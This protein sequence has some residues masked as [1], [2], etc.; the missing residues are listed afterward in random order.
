MPEFFSGMGGYGNAHDYNEKKKTKGK[1]K[2]LRL[3][4][5]KWKMGKI[6]QDWFNL[7]RLNQSL[8]TKVPEIFVGSGFGR[9]R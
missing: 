9:G 8:P 1:T 4:Y 6:R 2:K 7:P 5:E 3:T